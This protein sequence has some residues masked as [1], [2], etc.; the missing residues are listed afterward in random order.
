P[1]RAAVTSPASLTAAAAN[2]LLGSEN[3]D[4]GF[5]AAPGQPSDQLFAGWAALGLASAGH[6]LNRLGDAQSLMDYIRSGAGTR[7]VGALERTIL[8]VRAAGQSARSFGGR[9]LIA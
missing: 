4:G 6:D 3:A 5:G 7:D 1:A 2:Y 8:V 9:D